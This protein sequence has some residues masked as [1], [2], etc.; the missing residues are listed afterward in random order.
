MEDTSILLYIMCPVLKKKKEE[1]EE[2]EE[3]IRCSINIV[4]KI[5]K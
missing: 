2:E 1:E 5:F 4:E 3:K